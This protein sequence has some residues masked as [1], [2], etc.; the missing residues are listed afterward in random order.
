MIENRLASNSDH[1]HV[2]GHLVRLGLLDYFD[3][4]RCIEDVPA[5]KPAPI[6]TCAVID[7]FEIDGACAIAFEDSEHGVLAAKRAG[8]W[9][10]AVPGPSSVNHDLA[11]ADL[12]LASLADRPLSDL[13]KKFAR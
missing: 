12:V 8:L 4:L 1:P 3:Y 5:G 7:K 10:V 9:C 2:E 11:Q 13:L 6:C